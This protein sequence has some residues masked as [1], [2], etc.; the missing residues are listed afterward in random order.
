MVHPFLRRGLSVLFAASLV[1]SAGCSGGGGDKAKT[2]GAKK[3]ETGPIKVGSFLSMTGGTATF[4]QSCGNGIKL[5]I[6]EINAQGGVLGRQVELILEDDRSLA[7]EAKTAAVKLIQQDKVVALLGEVASS[8]SLAAA[9]DAQRAGVPMISPAS[10]NP[11]VTETGDYIFRVCFIDPFQGQVMAKF[12]INT[13]QAKSAAVFTD[14]K[15]DYSV[16][17]AQYFKNTFAEM[18]GSIVSE[19]SFAQGDIDFKAQLTSIKSKNPDVI[20]IPGYYTE[21]GQIARQARE[22]GITAKFL[23]GDGWDSPETAQIGGAAVEGAYFSNHYSAEDPN[24]VVQNYVAKFKAKYN[25]EPDGMGVLGYDAANVLFDAMKRAGT[26][27]GPAL[28]DAIAATKG[29]E[30]VSGIINID[31]NRNAVKSAV[32][33]EISGGKYKYTETIAP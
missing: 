31:E 8:S 17:L 2:D 32:V 12:A 25:A 11:K 30:G 20:F 15:S 26:T 10:T 29:F 27:D 33:L 5:A 14:V 7:Q 16:G 19:E 22:L 21:V 13:L 24:P 6:E 9:P 28:R 18:G 4:G 1:F 3:A 23:G